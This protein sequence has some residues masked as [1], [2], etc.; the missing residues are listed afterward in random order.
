MKL[1]LWALIFSYLGLFSSCSSIK[2]MAI[3]TASELLF[4]ASDSLL[5]ESDF[6]KFKNATMANLQLAEMMLFH[7]PADLDLLAVLVKG[8]AGH[9]YAVDESFYLAD[10]YEGIEDGP[11]WEN[12]I[13]HYS[14]A[15]EY[16]LRYLQ[17]KGLSYEQISIAVNKEGGIFR[18]L[19]KNLD[20]SKRNI[21]VVLFMAQSLGGLVN[22]QKT[23]MEMIAQLP[24][25]KG[26]FDWVCF[27]NSNIHFGL[28]GIF[29]GAYEGGRPKVLGGNPDHAREYFEKVIFENPDNWMARVAYAQYFLIPRSLKS[30]YEEQKIFLE[31]AARRL[32]ESKRWTPRSAKEDEFAAKELRFY[33]TLA[34]ERFKIMS[35]YESSF[36]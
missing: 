15:L 9:A 29:Y 34:I 4:Q 31:S 8:Y 7:S 5:E 18:L 26:L 2:K 36:F 33:Q 30:E 17:Q 14:K 6:Q 32:S 22:L 3:G 35:K 13:A 21:E 16:G 24:V 12:S 20:D 10:F 19:E 27:K 28:C 1:P 23:K 11:H 25:V